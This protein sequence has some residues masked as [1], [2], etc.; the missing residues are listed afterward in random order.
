MIA[1]HIKLRV[2][3]K[4]WWVGLVFCAFFIF[5]ACD[6]PDGV[7][8]YEGQTFIKLF[9]GNGSEKG[10]DLLQLPDGG[11][12]LVGSTT[13]RFQNEPET[14][15]GNKDVYVVRTDKQGN[16]KWEKS[17]HKNRHDIGSSVILQI[18]GADSSLFVCGE[19]GPNALTRNVYVL[20]ISLG[21]GESLPE[22]RKEYGKVDRD[23]FGT[24]ILDIEDGGFLITSTW[25]TSDT[26]S[27]FM[28]ETDDN[29]NALPKKED[30]VYGTKGVDNL[31]TNSFALNQNTP[32][33]PP[34]VCFGSVE[35]FYVNDEENTLKTFQ[36]QSFM[37]RPSNDKGISPNRYGGDIFDEFCTD[38]ATTSDGGF[39]LAGYQLGNDKESKEEM[40]VRL[41]ANRNEI[42]NYVYSNDF[43]RSIGDVVGIIQTKDGGFMLSSK[44]ELDD[45]VNDEIS[46]LKLN[47]VGDFEWRQTFGSNENDEAVKV[48]QLEDES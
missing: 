14:L 30:Y 18:A 35:E 39:I 45:P 4:M 19:T 2:T 20:K 26:S 38:A 9:G 29:L 23:E 15:I 6:T 37:Y 48:I 21:D 43:E 24:S 36:F 1:Y 28:V 46:L 5:N 47:S 11:F 16:I 25:L 7:E 27:F 31:S 41:D 22:N 40:A 8:P 34:F 12:I 3:T 44:I 42:W 32:L 33:N 17:Y 13:S 10:R